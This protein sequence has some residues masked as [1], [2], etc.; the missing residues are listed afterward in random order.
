MMMCIAVAALDRG[1]GMNAS[2]AWHVSVMRRGRQRATPAGGVATGTD[3]RKCL[4]GLLQHPDSFSLSSSPQ[5]ASSMAAVGGLEP[6]LPHR[7][8]CP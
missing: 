2:V 6:R 3:P 1:N 7:W 8:I 5:G 4:G